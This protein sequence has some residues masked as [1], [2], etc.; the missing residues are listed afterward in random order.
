M[1]ILVFGKSGQVGRELALTGRVVS[2]GRDVA[3]LS[4]PVACADKIRDL[5]PAVVINAAAYTAVDTAETDVEMADLVNGQAPGAMALAC[6]DIGIPFLHISTDYVF[7][8]TGE[9]PWATTDR[10]NPIGVY[11][12]SKLAGEI[13]V[14][15]AGG[16]FA[17]LR[18]SWVFSNHGNNFVRTMLRLG[19]ERGELSVVADQIGGPTAARD[20]AAA[21]LTMADQMSGD[22][23][24]GGIQHFSGAPD[25]SW[26]SFAREIFKQ[27]GLS[28]AVKD[29]STAEFPTP[30]A[31]P[32]NSRLDCSALRDDFAIAQP[33]WRLSLA[34]VLGELA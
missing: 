28:V 3:D 25:V 9:K 34:Q 6:A 18:T 20:I 27:A 22:A 33:D 15:E 13:A 24:L 31:R 12:R 1:S 11:G 29:I 14:R 32:A 8:G 4:D 21:L 17:I 10:P 19:A 16:Q 2:L 7:D 23:A 5:R 26:A 30:A